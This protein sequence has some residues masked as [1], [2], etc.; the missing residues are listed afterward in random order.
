MKSSKSNGTSKDF[1][2]DNYTARM[3]AF[4]GCRIALS[5]VNSNK[6]Q[7]LKDRRYCSLKCLQKQYF[8]LSYNG[9]I[10]LIHQSFGPDHPV[11]K[12]I[13]LMRKELAELRKDTDYLDKMARGYEH[14]DKNFIK[15]IKGSEKCL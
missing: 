6:H 15:L 1:K 3:C 13:Q 10:H 9:A 8:S 7:V 11:V 5:Y 14:Q 2:F 4:D 12:Q